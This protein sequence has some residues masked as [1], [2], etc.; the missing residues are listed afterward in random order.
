MAYSVLFSYILT[1][2]RVLPPASAARSGQVVVLQHGLM[3]TSATWVINQPTESLGY[4]LAADGHD[5]WLAN[6]R[7]SSYSKHK[8]WKNS[9]SK[10]WEFDFDQVRSQGVGSTCAAQLLTV[11]LVLAFFLLRCFALHSLCVCVC[12]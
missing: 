1:I 11:P 4:Q 5:V 8:T 9:D 10:F 3:D 2:H 12:V 7:G 6:S